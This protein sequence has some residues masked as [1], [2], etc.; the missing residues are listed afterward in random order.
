MRRPHP[1]PRAHREVEALTQSDELLGDSSTANRFFL[2]VAY[3]NLGDHDQSRAQYD[4]AVAS[5]DSD[6]PG[7]IHLARYLAITDALLNP[8]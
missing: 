1:C 4:A 2:A 6:A 8:K 7:D 3:W 5:I